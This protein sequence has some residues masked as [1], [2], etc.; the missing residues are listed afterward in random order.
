MSIQTVF[1]GPFKTCYVIVTFDESGYHASASC[2]DRQPTINEMKEIQDEFLPKDKVFVMIFPPPNLRIVGPN[3]NV[4]HLEEIKDS[5]FAQ[6]SKYLLDKQTITKKAI[7]DLVQQIKNQT[8][9][10]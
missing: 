4:I 5:D 8:A 10:N 1:R 2:L 9:N 7:D 3:P 6:Y